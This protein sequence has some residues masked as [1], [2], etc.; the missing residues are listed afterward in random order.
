MR[1]ASYAL[2][3]NPSCIS[4]IIVS[5]HKTFQKTNVDETKTSDFYKI[6]E[7]A[8]KQQFFEKEPKSYSIMCL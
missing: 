3:N 4:L 5:C 6:M 1:K 7:T 2:S 8:Q